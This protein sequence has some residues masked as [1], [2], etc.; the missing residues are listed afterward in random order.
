MIATRGLF[1]KRLIKK[2][3]PNFEMDG[4]TIHAHSDYSR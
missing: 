2:S 3:C 4:A 1:L